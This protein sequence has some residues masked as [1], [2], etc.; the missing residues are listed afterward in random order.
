MRIIRPGGDVPSEH[1]GMK[2]KSELK[3]GDDKSMS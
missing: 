1:F 3:F 2:S